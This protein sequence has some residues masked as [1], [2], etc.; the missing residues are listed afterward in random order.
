MITIVKLGPRNKEH[1]L[2]N[3][4]FVYR[5]IKLWNQLPT[6]PLATVTCKPHVFRKRD[7]KVISEEKWEGF[8]GWWRKVQKGREV[9]NGGE[10]MGS[11]VKWREV[12]WSEV[13]VFGEICVLSLTYSYVALCM[14]FAVRYVIIICCYLLFYLQLCSCMYVL[15]STL[16][17]YYLLLFVILFRVM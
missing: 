9:K 10:V 17:H 16:C 13:M 3:T 5:T 15:C 2:V 11:A 1:I 14:F 7:R 8:E 4:S 12:M 6:E